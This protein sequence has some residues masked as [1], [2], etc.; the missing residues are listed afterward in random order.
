MDAARLDTTFHRLGSILV[1]AAA[2]AGK[3]S[4]GPPRPRRDKPY[5]DQECRS[6]RAKFRY[7]VRHDPENVRILAR[8][9]SSVIRRKCRQYRQRQT[10][11]LLRHLR[12]NHKI[13]WQK[14]NSHDSTLPPALQHHS[15]WASFHERLWAPPA[16]PLQP[17][18]CATPPQC[19]PPVQ[20][21]EGPITHVEVQ[22]TLAKL[23][24]GRA[25][26]QAGWPAELLRYAAYYV[27]GEDGSKFKVWMLASL[28]TSFLNACCRRGQLPA[29]ISSAMVTPVHKKGC[30]LDPSNYR[31]IAVGEP[32]Y[33]LYTTILNSRL[34]AWS[35]KHQLRSPAQRAFARSNQPFITC[36]PFVISLT[37]PSYASVVCLSA[38][39]TSR[40]PTTLCSTS[41]RGPGSEPLE[42]ALECQQP[43][44]PCM[45]AARFQ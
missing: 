10:P 14:L 18:P 39:W 11:A 34:V 8:R 19:S 43:S 25:D 13:F 6:L 7:A 23:P 21:L 5:F 36:L 44:G 22:R 32:L 42:L 20:D 16:A 9:F 12:S 40:R 31:P 35:E 17:D 37:K 28:L 26:G 24:N 33:R 38:L 15:A 30:A 27:E 41:P 2:A 45:P 1:E 3:V 29:C 4:S